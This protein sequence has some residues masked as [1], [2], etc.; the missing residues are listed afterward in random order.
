MWPL[1]AIQDRRTPPS[2]PS[3]CGVKVLAGG[4]VLSSAKTVHHWPATTENFISIVTTFAQD[5]E[6]E[7]YEIKS[8]G[9]LLERSSPVDSHGPAAGSRPFWQAAEVRDDSTFTSL[10]RRGFGSRT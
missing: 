3:P 6:I 2:S 1:Q 10:S 8:H 9:V 5:R 7:I 4:L